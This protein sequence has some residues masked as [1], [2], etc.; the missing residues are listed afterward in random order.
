M[1]H[2]LTG[3]DMAKPDVGRRCRDHAAFKPG[4]QAGAPHL[5]RTIM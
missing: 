1:K 4:K 3:G 2:R 5:Y